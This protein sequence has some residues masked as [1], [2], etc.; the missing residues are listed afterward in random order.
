MTNVV[1]WDAFNRVSN[2]LLP[3]TNHL[4]LP[5]LGHKALT[6]D[7]PNRWEIGLSDNLVIVNGKL[8][9]LCHNVLALG[10]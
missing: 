1:F 6:G 10:E 3:F 2:K 4:W 9:F 8:E 5:V 7:V